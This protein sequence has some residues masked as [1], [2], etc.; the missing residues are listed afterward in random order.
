MKSRTADGIVKI[1]PV[2]REQQEQG[3]SVR[4]TTNEDASVTPVQAVASLSEA[5]SC[6]T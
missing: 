5:Q 6:N 1:D 3:C 2:K 4:G